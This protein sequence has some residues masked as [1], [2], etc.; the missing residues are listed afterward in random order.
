MKSLSHLPL[1][2]TIPLT[3]IAIAAVA[4]CFSTPMS[5]VIGWSAAYDS[6]EGD[7]RLFLTQA[8][9]FV[10]V[11]LKH[12]RV[13]QLEGLLLAFRDNISVTSAHLLGPDD[14]VLDSWGRQPPPPTWTA[15][16]ATWPPGVAADLRARAE[17]TRSVQS[18]V[19]RD[20]RRILV[21][22]TVQAT[23]G[24]P[25]A[26]AY[27][28]TMEYDVN[29]GLDEVLGAASL[30]LGIFFV[31]VFGLAIAA[32]ATLRWLLRH[33]SA[34]LLR[35]ARDIAH[36]NF[37][38]RVGGSVDD[39]FGAV[40]AA[41]DDMAA[42]LAETRER[43]RQ[44]EERYRTL[45]EEADDAVLLCD[46]GGSVQD[47]NHA[48]V[49][50][51]GRTTDQLRGANVDTIVVLDSAGPLAARSRSG[52]TAIGRAGARGAD[53]TIVPV[54]F[55]VRTHA[56]LGTLALFR[57]LRQELEAA[58]MRDALVVQERLAALGTLAAGVGHEL[59]NP[60]SYVAG[61]LELIEAA[62]QNRTATH[63]PSSSS[64]PA[65]S[66]TRTTAS[67]SLDLMALV[68]DARDG[69]AR[70]KRIVGELHVFTRAARDR[71]TADELESC[72]DVATE[73][74]AAVHLA[75]HALK[76][77]ARVHRKIDAGLPPV[78]GEEGRL[79]QVVVNLLTNAARAMPPDR[80]P[81][82]NAITL[83]ATVNDGG[84]T[85]FVEVIDNGMGIDPAVLPHVFAPFFT[86]R[87]TAGGSGLGLSVSRELVLAMGG[88]IDVQ[89]MP[90]GGGCTF[91][92]RL[93][94]V[95]KTKAAPSTPPSP[96][97]VGG[98]AA[99]QDDIH[100]ARVLIV[101]DDPLVARVL[102]LML[103]RADV[104]VA[105]GVAEA[106]A[107]A[108]HHD[109]DC[110]LC[111]LIMP[112]GGGEAVVRGWQENDPRILERVF[113]MTAG[114]P[115]P[116]LKAFVDRAGRPVLEKPLD[117][118][119][120]RRVVGEQ[121]RLRRSGDAPA[122]RVAPDTDGTGPAASPASPAPTAPTPPARTEP[123]SS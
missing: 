90:G 26:G 60:L 58:Q 86:T 53:G 108:R 54:E 57:D 6:A 16:T 61:N 38:A 100:G 119:T 89:T 49:A 83:R 10:D 22:H 2:R 78:R 114:I 121:V 30:A 92:L 12:Q 70:M 42:R 17:T 112:D 41:I 59:N 43:N 97:P 122:P 24:P 56:G 62:L 113:F 5:V 67:P 68:R 13:D 63:D 96:S 27:L 11:A 101:D 9:T 73:I 106:I 1:R 20:A 99:T 107:A 37:E 28:L 72:V 80:D 14:R 115:S 123:A 103:G 87:T 98:I 104:T 75:D 64:S 44:N 19:D 109:F 25:G 36:G 77:H 7:S 102:L 4:C 23:G 79:A 31:F 117:A 8:G 3:A 48:A 15:A 111:D 84:D 93:P 71:R 110:L 35:V 51:F 21:V 66:D 50:L 18:F 74:D 76:G 29:K 69:A 118:A 81:A 33:R 105:G 45:F 55:H 34:I 82:D 88:T 91:R 120:L 47:A 65:T 46:D 85:V 52:V 94:G 116:E 40:A 95:P 32:G 39:E